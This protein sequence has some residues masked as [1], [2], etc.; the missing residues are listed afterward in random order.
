MNGLRRLLASEDG[1]TLVEYAL[2]ISL[3]AATI[4]GSAKLF[5]NALYNMYVRIAQTLQGA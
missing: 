2:L 5:G 4:I 3:I 1:A